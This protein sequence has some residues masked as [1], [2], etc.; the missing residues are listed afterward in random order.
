MNIEA[1]EVGLDFYEMLDK[2]INIRLQKRQIYGDTYLEDT[3]EF[4]L[5]QMENKLKRI[6]LNL[7][8]NQTNAI[9][10]VI[11][12]CLDVGIYSLFLAANWSNTNKNAK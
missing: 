7:K 8:N 10:N 4:L 1:E 11:D 2:L 3:P 5:M 6:R 12:N 9:E